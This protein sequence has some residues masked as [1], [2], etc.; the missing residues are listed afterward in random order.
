MITTPHI[1]ACGT[2]IPFLGVIL[3]FAIRI[4]ALCLPDASAQT[5]YT[6]AQHAVSEGSANAAR[7]GSSKALG[8]RVDLGKLIGSV[9]LN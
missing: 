3:L 2:A 9:A 5:T 6:T 8:G 4:R 1:S 7:D